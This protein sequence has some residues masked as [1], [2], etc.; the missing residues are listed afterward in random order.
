MKNSKTLSNIPKDKAKCAF[1]CGSEE[2]THQTWNCVKFNI[3]TLSLDEF[4]TTITERNKS[5][6]ETI[7]DK[8]SETYKYLL[9]MREASDDEE[10]DKNF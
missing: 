1:H 4:I 2:S 5:Y 8:F 3:K 10:H 6:A 7:I 9:E